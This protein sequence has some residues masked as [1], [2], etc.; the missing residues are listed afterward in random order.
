MKDYNRISQLTKGVASPRV[1]V[2][3]TGDSVKIEGVKSV[4]DNGNVTLKLDNGETVQAD[5]VVFETSTTENLYSI[6]SKYGALGVETFVNTYNGE[7]VNRYAPAFD[8][9]YKFGVADPDGKLW[10]SAKNTALAEWLNPAQ[11]KAAYELGRA[12]AQNKSQT[13][14]VEINTKRTTNQ[15]KNKTSQIGSQRA[16]EG[17]DKSKI[18]TENLSPKQKASLIESTEWYFLL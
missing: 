17:V 10:E 2:K 3:S 5:E 4:D 15:A 11:A 7:D 16:R 13:A 12:Y 6:G 8:S 1:T 9:F 18:N 14:Q